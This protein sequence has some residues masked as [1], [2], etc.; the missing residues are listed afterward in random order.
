MPL[1]MV[2]QSASLKAACH[3]RQDRS[4]EHGSRAVD[5][6]GGG[7]QELR[8]VKVPKTIVERVEKEM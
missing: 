8:A 7:G 2:I 5:V 6:G 4:H 3:A 1:E